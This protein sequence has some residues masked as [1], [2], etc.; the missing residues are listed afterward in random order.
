MNQTVTFAAPPSM[1]NLDTYH[2][3]S[4][5]LFFFLSVFEIQAKVRFLNMIFNIFLTIHI[6][7]ML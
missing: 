4:K 6:V 1:L 7:D 3:D 2:R 5:M